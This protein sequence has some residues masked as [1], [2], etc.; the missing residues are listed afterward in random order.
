MLMITHSALLIICNW[1]VILLI[2]TSA[3]ALMTITITMTMTTPP[4]TSYTRPRPSWRPSCSLP[5][6]SPTRSHRRL[7]AMPSSSSYDDAIQI[8]APPHQHHCMV[9]LPASLA[10]LLSAIINVITIILII[11]DVMI[12]YDNMSGADL[13]FSTL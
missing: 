3:T 8:P 5:P 9:G 12:I 1:L 4:P 10:T 11:C 7:K 6:R 2:T 13:D